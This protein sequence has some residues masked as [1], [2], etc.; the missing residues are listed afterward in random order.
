MK[1]ISKYIGRRIAK[2][3][4]KQGLSQERLAEL[5]DL[6][7]NYIGTVER[8]EVNIG[9]NNIYKITSALNIKMEVLFKNF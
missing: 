7:H 6:H 2:E 9:V 3:R 1:N 4:K 5:A 8:G